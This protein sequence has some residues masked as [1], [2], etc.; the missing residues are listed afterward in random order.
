MFG[1]YEDYGGFEGGY[2]GGWNPQ[3]YITE[4]IPMQTYH[5]K[6]GKPYLDL[7]A[8]AL[9]K[10]KSLDKRILLLENIYKSAKMM[11][12]HPQI[13]KTLKKTYS[14]LAAAAMRAMSLEYK[15]KLKKKL[16]PYN[17]ARKAMG[18]KVSEYKTTLGYMPRKGLA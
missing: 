12:Y 8:W 3:T 18:Q 13:T 14:L 2:E 1:G 6:A 9:T 7:R 17:A 4:D 5:N 15:W 11:K 16:A 10:E